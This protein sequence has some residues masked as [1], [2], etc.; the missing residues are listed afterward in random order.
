MQYNI[1]SDSHHD[2]STKR[3]A[4]SYGRQS[5]GKVTFGSS[6]SLLYQLHMLAENI[7][8]MNVHATSNTAT[9]CHVVFYCKHNARRIM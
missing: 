3:I 4:S 6:F 8:L 2:Q 5:F 7:H 1:V 9:V